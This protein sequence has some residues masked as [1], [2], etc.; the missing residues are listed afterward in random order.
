MIF[1]KKEVIVSKECMEWLEKA[2]SSEVS[3]EQAKEIFDK[4]ASQIQEDVLKTLMTE[5]EEP[6]SPEGKTEIVVEVRLAR[7]SKLGIA[8]VVTSVYAVVYI[9][10]NKKKFYIVLDEN[11][12]PKKVPEIGDEI[13]FSNNGGKFFEQLKTVESKKYRIS[14]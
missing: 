4:K 6:A 9:K 5:S 8:M 3:Q 14:M 12:R 1:R 10:G 2:E 11:K 7:A 13:F